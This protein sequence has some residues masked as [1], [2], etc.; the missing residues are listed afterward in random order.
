MEKAI[1][2]ARVSSREQEETGYSLQAQKELLKSHTEGKLSVS[3]I[4]SIA[5]SATSKQGR[6]VFDE[7][8]RYSAKHNIPNIICEKIDRLTRT[9]KD[10]GIVDDWVREKKGRRVHFV[11]ESFVLSCDT[12][13]HENFIWNMKVAVAKFYTDNLSE[14]V[15]KGQKAKL[16][17]G[18]LPS[19]PPLGYK[20][21]GEK[22]KKIHVV[23]EKDAV[24]IR[25][26]FKYYATGNYSLSALVEKLYSEGFRTRN[27]GKL[28]KSRLDKMLSEPFYYGAIRWKDVVYDRGSQEP[29]IT[30]EL[31]DKVH[32]IKTRKVAPQ[33]N[34]H[35]FQFR[36]SMVCGE[37]GGTITGENQKGIV[38]YH[39]NHYKKCEQKKYTTEEQVEEQL[40]GVFDLFANLTE[41]EAEEIKI[42]IKDN[43]AQEIEYK[44]G[45][46]MTL[47]GQYNA[48]QR[49]LD[50]LYDDRLDEKISVEK[51]EEKQKE[52]T[53][54]QKQIQKQ[55]GKLKNEE[56]KYFELYLNIIDL[57]RRA[58]SIYEK[59][60]PEERRLLLSHIFSNLMLKDG[61][62]TY[63]LKEP[64]EVLAKRVQERIDSRNTFEPTK[65]GSDARQKDPLRSLHPSMLR[66]QDSNL[67]QI[68]YTYPCV[69]AWGGLYHHP[70]GY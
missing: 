7:M 52:I 15:K 24:Y 44:D 61:S 33:Y 55:I 11:K 9:P 57:A 40:L 47:Q 56:A 46:L 6:K 13:A 17:E 27:G 30:K 59:R 10:A 70:L 12:K 26:A 63:K 20:T 5:E 67:R 42:L 21:V 2:Y 65:N 31:F 8:L 28:C 22:G 64:V 29:L 68:D 35:E 32:D 69:S 45:V 43:H 41:A 66:R 50:N 36:K 53:D 38:Y 34:R 23:D 62:V 58:R 19:K 51:W 39:C 18:W 60:T 4:F 48:L 37:C 3:K 25:T 1:I 54:S 14:E 49:R 16:A